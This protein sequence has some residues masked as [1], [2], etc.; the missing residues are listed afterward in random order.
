MKAGEDKPSPLPYTENTYPTI[1]GF[2]CQN[3]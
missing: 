2:G 1:A 3:S